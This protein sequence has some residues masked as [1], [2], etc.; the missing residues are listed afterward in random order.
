MNNLFDIKG[1]VAVVTGGSRGIGE[2][3]AEGFVAAGAK[4][5]ISS[6]KADACEAV[7][8]RLSEQGDCI[9]LPADLGTSE[10]VEALA[11]A[12]AEREEKIDILVNNAGATWGAPIDEF[13][14]DGWDRVMNLNVKY[15]FFLTKALLPQLRAASSEEDPARVINIA[16][17]D[18]M[19]P[20]D[21]ETY[22]YQAS[23][24]AVVH[25]TRSLAKRLAKEDICVNSIAPGPFESK[26]TAFF[27][28]NEEGRQ[29]VEGHNPRKRIGS[30]EDAA[31]VA[32]FLSSR[33]S[34]YITG[35][36]IPLDGGIVNLAAR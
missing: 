21:M 23:K 24:A 15:L 34:A 30:P 1:K 9:P 2:M 17:I 4:V 14:E 20:S 13:P 29:A 26:M 22:S 19:T 28:S 27:L 8:K 3:I 31:G 18:G 35:A 25:L 7:A 36:N 32:I 6:R 12:L 16:S 33:A 5:Y 10:G 11:K